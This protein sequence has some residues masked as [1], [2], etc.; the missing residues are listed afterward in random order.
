MLV[1]VADHHRCQ[2][3][4]TDR[5]KPPWTNIASFVNPSASVAEHDLGNDSPGRVLN[6][7]SGAHQAYAAPSSI[8]EEALRKFSRAIADWMA[9]R[10]GTDCE[11]AIALVAEPRL[12][13]EIKEACP[14]AVRHKV[15][16]ELPKDLTHA[17]LP[18][19]AERLRAAAAERW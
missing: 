19:L 15:A 7:G 11:A 10:T 13:H 16:L 9:H 2:C 1:I 12:L 14:P 6:R 8:H 5:L 4:A 18:D 17:A 3:Y